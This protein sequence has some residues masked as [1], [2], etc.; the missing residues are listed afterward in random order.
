MM[1]EEP[2]MAV[3][4]EETPKASLIDQFPPQERGE[5]SEMGLRDP[6]EP[7]GFTRLRT[8]VHSCK[9]EDCPHSDC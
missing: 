5:L 7:H 1:R 2:E 4:R 8:Q 3:N 6:E 9:P